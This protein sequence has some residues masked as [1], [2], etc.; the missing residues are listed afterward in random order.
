MSSDPPTTPG[1]PLGAAGPGPSDRRRDPNGPPDP[2][3]ADGDPA[4]TGRGAAGSAET[5]AGSAEIAAGDANIDIE[6]D[7]DAAAPPTPPS[8]GAGRARHRRPARRWL[9]NVLLGSGVVVVALVAAAVL[10]YQH[11]VNPGPAGPGEIVSVRPGSSVGAVAATL[12]RQHVIGSGIAFRIYL[13]LHGTPM[14]QPGLY[15]FHRHQAL[16]GVLATLSSGPDV[17]AVTVEPGTTV[18]EVATTIGG[19]PGHSPSALRAAAATVHSPWQPAGSANLDG[20]LGT[21]SYLILPGETATAVLDQ[22]VTRFDRQAA[23]ADLQARAAALGFTPYQAIIVAS[24]VQKEAFSPG[25]S[26]AATA[27]NAGRV[28]RVIDNRLAA[29]MPLQDDST[30]LYALGRDGGP[31]TSEDLQLDSPYNTYLYP[32]LTPTPICFPSSQAL[33]AALDPTPGTW[34][35]FVLTSKDGTETFSVTF[36]Q[37]L[38]AEALARSRGLP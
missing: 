25:D 20:L 33:Q 14:V 23:A 38:A 11:Q 36:Q 21:G 4:G 1:R 31:V 3:S 19:L 26:A 13:F 29:G 8:R 9:R 16:S 6:I 22:M 35:Y 34:R 37:Q 32:G 5:S 15:L 18:S 2:E 10:W 28:A 27:Y 12:G 24:I 30:V 7:G 17:F